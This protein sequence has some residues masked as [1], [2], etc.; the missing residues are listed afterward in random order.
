VPELTGVH[1]GWRIARGQAA[2][3]LKFALAAVLPARAPYL[4]LHS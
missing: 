4:A 1:I 3:S 2:G